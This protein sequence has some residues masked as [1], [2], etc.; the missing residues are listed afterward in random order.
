ME[1]VARRQDNRARNE[2]A[3]AKTRRLRLRGA[4]AGYDAKLAENDAAL[5]FIDEWLIAEGCGYRTSSWIE[6]GM[7]A[8]SNHVLTL[9]RRRPPR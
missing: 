1:A 7:A 6:R 4:L 2:A 5:L 8:W 3:N 9:D